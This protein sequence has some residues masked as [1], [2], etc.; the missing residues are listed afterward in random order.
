MEERVPEGSFIM[1]PRHQ[2]DIRQT[3]EEHRM[4]LD[5]NLVDAARDLLERR[6]PGDGDVL[7]SVFFEPEWGSGM[8]CAETGAICE[9]EKLGKRVTASVCVSRLSG[10]DPV[11]ILTPCGICQE[12]LFHW[13]PDLEVAVPD[14]ADSTRWMAR[15]LKEVQPYYWV[16]AF[17]SG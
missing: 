1:S 13:G 11:L 2:R 12:R 5:Q 9:A 14:P 16:N 6:F 8:L 3:H 4:R 10:E 7:T 15:T 17:E